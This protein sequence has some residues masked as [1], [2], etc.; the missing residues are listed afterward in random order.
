MNPEAR[1]APDALANPYAIYHQLRTMAPIHW[2]SGRQLWQVTSYADVSLLLRDPRLSAQRVVPNRTALSE[3]AKALLKPLDRCFELWLVF[4]EPPDHTPLRNYCASVLTPPSLASL[5]ARIQRNI[6][7]LLDAVAHQENFDFIRSFAYPL[8]AM[9]ICDMLDIPEEDVP[10]IADWLRTV[11]AAFGTGSN[12]DE[13]A[14]SFRDISLY[15]S[16]LIRRPTVKTNAL[17]DACRNGS[18]TQEEFIANYV[19]LLLAGHDTTTNMIGN[20]LLSLLENP[21][22]LASLRSDPTL[23]SP[24]IEEL[25]RFES[26]V[27]MVYRTVMETMTVSGRT[28]HKGQPVLLSVGGANRD[29]AKFPA[30]DTLQLRRKPNPHLAFIAGVHQCLGAQIA[31][32]E[33][34]LVWSTLLRR[35][36]SFQLAEATTHWVGKPGVRGLERLLIQVKHA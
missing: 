35:F 4:R 11:V 31:R 18:L 2:D 15:L 26:P 9:N 32:L 7:K 24:A 16:D 13:A 1:Q 17:V 25:L 36:Q 20:G 28:L 30:P 3:A 29:P 19:F 22:E 27:Q 33:A 6:D 21:V 5:S 34:R 23:L 14:R 10:A 8:P 12:F